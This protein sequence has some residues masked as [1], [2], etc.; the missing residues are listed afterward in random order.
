MKVA[1]A[2]DGTQVA[3]HFGRCEKYVIAELDDGAVTAEETVPN[4]GHEPGLLPRM[5]NQMGVGTIVAGGMGPRAVALFEQFGIA[6]IAGV[7]GP[8]A[9]TLEQLAAGELTPGESTCEH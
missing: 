9:E 7:S 6:V 5:L 3:S 4:P 8:V 2:T 1:V